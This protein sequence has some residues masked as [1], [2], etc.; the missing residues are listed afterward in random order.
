MPRAP[1]FPLT[2]YDDDG[3]L[4]PGWVLWLVILFLCRHLLILGLGALST[5]V[6][7]GRG[8]EGQATG[9]MY[10]DP[11]L[12]IASLP[13]L[14]V[15]AAAMRRHPA[16]GLW[17]RRIWH[18]GRPL[19]AMAALCDLAIRGAAWASAHVAL[20]EMQLAM[21]LA[22]IY[23]VVYLYRSRRVAAVFADF[24]APPGGADR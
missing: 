7:A 23:V 12:L 10:S 11:R 3:T 5:F 21:A 22:D 1:R 24:P 8:I 9:F 6:G 17:A 18:R 16:A 20:S 4:L 19:L 2:A 14:L 15:L 13:A